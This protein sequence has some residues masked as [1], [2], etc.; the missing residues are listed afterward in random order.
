M[1]SDKKEKKYTVNNFKILDAILNPIIV[2]D[3][4]YKIV[5]VNKAAEKAYSL[6]QSDCLG[7]NCSILGFSTCKTEEC[8]IKKYKKGE[9]EELQC[10]WNNEGERVT[11]SVLY[12]EDGKQIGFIRVA[13]NISEYIEEKQKLKINEERLRIAL[14][15]TQSVIWEFDIEKQIFSVSELHSNSKIEDYWDLSV[16]EDISDAIIESGLVATESI[17]DLLHFYSAMKN[18]MNDTCCTIKVKNKLGEFRWL[19]VH[20]NSINDNFGNPIRAIG[21]F[22]DITEEKQKEEQ[23]KEKAEI[24]LLTGLYNRNTS[25]A[26]I[27]QELSERKYSTGALLILDLDNFKKINDTYGHLY[28][29]AVLSETAHKIV[30]NFRREDISGRLGGD[31]FIVYMR[32]IV[33]KETVLQKAEQMCNLLKTVYSS[34]QHRVEVSVSIGIAFFP[35]DGEHF[36]LLYDRADIALYQVKKLGRN[37]YR[38]FEHGM[39]KDKVKCIGTEVRN[40]ASLRKTFSDNVTEYIFKI[41]YNSNDLEL[42]INSVLELLARHYDM[43]HGYVLEYMKDTNTYSMTF[44]WCGEECEQCIEYM[45]NIPLEDWNEIHERVQKGGIL[46]VNDIEKEDS[47]LKQLNKI[48]KTFILCQVMH[49]DEVLGLIGIDD[50]HGKKIFSNQE[51]ETIKTAVEIIGTFLKHKRQEQQKVKY[52][53]VLQAVLDYQENVIYIIRPDT[54]KVLYHNKKAKETFPKIKEGCVCHRCFFDSDLVCSDCPIDHLILNGSEKEK[55]CIFDKTAN[56]WIEAV[57]RWITWM[58]GNS[59]VMLSCLDIS[60]YKDS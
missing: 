26:L 35:Q 23:L 29:D 34:G 18:G 57:A 49:Q 5:Y 19:Y 16:F 32:N 24:D 27:R 43:H 17:E 55:V 53:S 3:L 15:Q 41:L 59:Y 58:D 2:M 45:Q 13:T 52:G 47:K 9:A 36:N 33:S 28:G 31:E 54:R 60:K 39:H 12:N 56:G 11:V 25:E 1:N 40:E 44:E 21:I 46:Y 38:M 37:G 4:N 30:K 14:Q 50:I 51:L 8:C 10:M 6:Y 42:T 48:A 20:S 22:K 7:K